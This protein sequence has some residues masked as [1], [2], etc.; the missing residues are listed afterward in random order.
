MVTAGGGVLSPEI[1]D[2]D[3]IP[4]QFPFSIDSEIKQDLIFSYGVGAGIDIGLSN[5]FTLSP[6]VTFERTTNS[7]W[8]FS[9]ENGSETFLDETI[10]NTFTAGIHLQYRWKDY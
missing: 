6:F 7:E 8:N 3:G 10:L 5:K 9:N 2:I 4:V 1:S